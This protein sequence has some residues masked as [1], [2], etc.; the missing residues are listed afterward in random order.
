[1]NDMTP[2]NEFETPFGV[3][4]LFDSRENRISSSA[5]SY[6]DGG[7]MYALLD[8]QGGNVAIDVERYTQA[9]PDIF[10]GLL[11]DGEDHIEFYSKWTIAEGISKLTN[12]PI[13]ERLKS[14][15][16]H[17]FPLEQKFRIFEDEGEFEGITCQFKEEEI[18]ISVIKRISR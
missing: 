16:L 18:L 3:I 6:D 7:R 1:M 13:L 8:S 4:Q 5:R 17:N 15:E 10:I 11:T 9:I 2:I 12:V 14:R